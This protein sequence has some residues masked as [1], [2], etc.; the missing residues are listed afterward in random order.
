MMT[1]KRIAVPVAVALAV[2]ACANQ[3][4]QPVINK[5]L[6]GTLGGAALGAYG[7][8]QFGSGTGQLAAVAV[9]TLA[10]AYFGGEIG[11]S[12]DKADQAYAQ[13]SAQNALE[14]NR[15]G[16]T[17]SWRNPDSGHAGATTPTRTYQNAKGQDCREYETVVT[18]DG[19]N[20][21]AIGRACREP[22]GVWR[23]VQ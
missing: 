16:E 15:T 11:R 17:S 12:L 5:E 3:G 22:G 23:I 1:V 14:Y 19:R 2:A 13:R 18:I 4:Q 7:G 6:I 20:E 21:K 8:A 9:G 10:G